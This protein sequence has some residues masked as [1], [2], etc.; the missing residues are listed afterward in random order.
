MATIDK[1]AIGF[2]IAIVAVGAGFA[3]YGETVQNTVQVPVTS[4]IELTPTTEEEEKSATYGTEKEEK[5]ATYGTEKEEKSAT[6]GTEKPKEMMPV[7]EEVMP[8]EETMPVE[9]EEEVMPVDTEPMTGPQTHTV[10]MPA[11]T[12]FPG[13]ELDNTCFIPQDITINAGDT[14]SWINDDSAAHTVTSGSVLDGPTYVFDSSLFMP[15]GVFEHTFDDPGTFE[16]FCMV[17]PWMAGTITV[18]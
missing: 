17:H 12:A 13:C 16:Y 8:V 9:E 18:N 15:D 10:T 4:S 14:I 2:S 11:G 7:E 1:A 3:M 6:Y 5:S